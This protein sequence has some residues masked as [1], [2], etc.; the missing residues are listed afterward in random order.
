[1]YDLSDI[2][3]GMDGAEQDPSESVFLVFREDELKK[4]KLPIAQYLL[5]RVI[6]PPCLS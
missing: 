1:M 3:V 4:S 2:D 5:G 6:I